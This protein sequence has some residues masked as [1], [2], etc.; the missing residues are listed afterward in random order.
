VLAIGGGVGTA[1]A[2]DL[3]KVPGT[4]TPNRVK[5]DY[6]KNQSGETDG[7]LADAGVDADA[8]ALVD[9]MGVDGVKGYVRSKDLI[10]PM[11]KTPEEALA[12]Q[13]RN[14]ERRIA[15]Y[16]VDGKTQIGEFVV[17]GTSK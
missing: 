10:P 2:G 1:I 6:K 7:S 11:P 15:L 3:P 12:S 13:A 14:K 16:E 5:P 9:A 17:G 8:P 4:D